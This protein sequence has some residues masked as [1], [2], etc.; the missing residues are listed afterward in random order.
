MNKHLE[1]LRKELKYDK[2]KA[3][4]QCGYCLPACPTYVTMG[5]ETHSPR[6]RINL[7][8][9][10]GEGK[11]TDLSVLEEPL[12]LCLGCR[13]C[14]TVCPTGVEY[15]SLLEAA[16]AAIIRRKQY[17]LPKRIARNL[18]FKKAFP[19]RRAMNL[20]ANAMWLYEKSGLQKAARK[21]GLIQ[22]LPG[23]LGEFEAIAPPAV[24]P[25]ERASLPEFSK[26][27]G[28]P[29]YSVAFFVGCV[30][31]AMFRKINML[32]VKL[33]CEVG[34]NVTIIKNQTCCG[35]L[36]AHSGELDESKALVRETLILSSITRAAVEQ[37]W[38]NMIIYWKTSRS[39]SNEQDNFQLNRGISRK[40][41]SYAEGFKERF[42]SRKE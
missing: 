39:G 31:D 36:H 21:S 41:S 9:M 34:C 30:M 5:K 14:E 29:K 18:I 26:A 3:C 25:F 38:R 16:R 42:G 32:S 37:L 7:I 11:I 27:K 20:V 33:L 35:A 19:S 17:S 40:L 12:D 22:K 15:G 1:E 13:A 2:T 4:V 6:G 23:H 28:N 24:S 10:V 8:K